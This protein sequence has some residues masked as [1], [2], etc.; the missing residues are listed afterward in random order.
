MCSTSLHIFLDNCRLRAGEGGDRGWDGWMASPTQW[1]WG[2]A[3]SGRWWRTGEP[4]VLQSMGSRRVRHDWNILACTHIRNSM[5]RSVYIF[6][7]FLPW[8]HLTKLWSDITVRI[9]TSTQSKHR[10]FH[11]DKDPWSALTTPPAPLKL[12]SPPP[13][14]PGSHESLL[15]L[16]NFVL[17]VCYRKVTSLQLI[18][19]NEKKKVGISSVLGEDEWLPMFKI[20]CM[21]SCELWPSIFYVKLTGIDFI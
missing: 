12:P 10:T 18:K 9:S 8:Y 20:L 15:H 14:I 5:E 7:R 17:L 16:Y 6:S 4:G 2:R 19:I 11:Q 21:L 1:T 3:N 13:L